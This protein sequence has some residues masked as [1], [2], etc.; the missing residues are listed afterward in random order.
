MKP[1]YVLN[2]YK[3]ILTEYEKSEVLDFRKIYFVG[4][5]AKKVHGDRSKEF[6]DGYDDERG[7]YKI[8]TGDHI[9]YRYEIKNCIGKGSFGQCYK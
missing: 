7:D 9:S 2:T 1:G 5:N 3:D 4:P 6:N 8:T